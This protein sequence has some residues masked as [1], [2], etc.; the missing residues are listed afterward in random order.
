MPRPM[1]PDPGT[2]MHGLIREIRTRVPFATPEASLCRGPCRGCS[3][4][5]LEFLD[6]ELEE[7]EGRLEEGEM[8][9]FGD[10]KRLEKLATK[11]MAALRRNGLVA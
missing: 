3:K 9:R 1:R 6:T 11:V 5:L 10:L 8:P 7:W 4:K 2:A